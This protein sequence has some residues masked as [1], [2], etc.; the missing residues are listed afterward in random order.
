[1]PFQ[2]ELLKL[3]GAFYLSNHALNGARLQHGKCF[4]Q[5]EQRFAVLLAGHGAGLERFQA[6]HH[7]GQEHLIGELDVMRR[8]HGAVLKA[9]R[10]VVRAGVTFSVFV[11]YYILIGWAGFAQSSESL[12]AQPVRL[13]FDLV[14]GD[15]AHL[16]CQELFDH[17]DFV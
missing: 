16:F 3:R 4:V 9:Q 5:V 14:G 12:Q 13:A 15:V 8:D 2:K 7:D 10:L 1:M 6:V 11:G 17:G